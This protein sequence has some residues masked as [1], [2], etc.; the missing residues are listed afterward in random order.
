MTE[1]A[2]VLDSM[3]NARRRTLEILENL[4][5]EQLDYQPAAGEDGQEWSLGE[6]FMHLAIDEIYLREMI[7]RPLMESVKPPDG[8]GFLPPPPPYGTSKDLIF[9]WFERARLQTRKLLEDWPGNANLVLK[10]HG[11]LQDMN[12]LQWLL[13]YASHELFHHQQIKTI[14]S[15]IGP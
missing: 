9:Y 3:E 2:E 15:Q 13:G 5:Q 8:I 6:V 4:S 10:H 11:G 7:A 12:A 1:P 14:L